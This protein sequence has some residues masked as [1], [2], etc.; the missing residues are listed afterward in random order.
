M[1]KYGLSMILPKEIRENFVLVDVKETET[2]WILTVE[3]KKD[4]IPEAAK[5]RDFGQ[6]IVLNG[7]RDTLELIGSNLTNKLCYIRLKRR[8][9]KIRGTKESFHN[10]YKLHPKGLQCTIEFGIFLKEL[11][12]QER[13]EFFATWKN[14]RHIREEDFSLV[15]RIKRFFARKKDL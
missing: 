13:R 2:E 8:R 12:R 14:I 5:Q 1:E 11:N 3:E 15:S 10:S 4:L 7:Y 6:G 9:W